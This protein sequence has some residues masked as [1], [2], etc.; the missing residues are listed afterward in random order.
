[1][2]Y[3]DDVD[4]KK[5]KPDL[6]NLWQVNQLTMVTDDTWIAN[7]YD[8]KVSY[9]QSRNMMTKFARSRSLRDKDFYS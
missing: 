4:E 5:I 1:M 2:D 3:D 9:M 7:T 6:K 8:A